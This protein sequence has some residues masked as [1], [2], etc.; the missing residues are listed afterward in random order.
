MRKKLNLVIIGYGR[1]GKVLKDILK[2]S[3]NLYFLDPKNN[4]QEEYIKKIELKDLKDM[5]II[6]IATPISKFEQ[7]IKEI[8][9]KV[10]DNTLILDVGSV[11]VYPR[12]LMEKHFKNRELELLGIHPM[13]GPDSVKS[14]FD[15]LQIVW[16]PMKEKEKSQNLKEV[17]K[18]AN[19]KIIETTPENHDQ[20]AA[21]SLALVHYIGRA[22]RKSEIEKQEITSLG[23]ERLL[24]IDETVNNDSWQLF[25]DMQRYNKYAKALRIKFRRVL[26][27]M[28]EEI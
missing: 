6:I 16:C 21:K 15:N 2:D 4:N 18:N 28:E 9:N 7:I 17:F 1:F 8:K 19:F 25:R 13:F 24:S 27:E 20:Q 12:K 3:F 5:D 22:L 26:R 10:K 23:F 11:K 14:G